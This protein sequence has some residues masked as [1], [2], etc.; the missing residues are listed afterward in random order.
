MINMRIK[1]TEK[2]VRGGKLKHD[3]MIKITTLI[4][5]L[6]GAAIVGTIFN[7]KFNLLYISRTTFLGGLVVAA[8]LIL[9]YQNKKLNDLEIMLG[10]KK[11]YEEGKLNPVAKKV[12]ETIQILRKRMKFMSEEQLFELFALI[13]VIGSMLLSFILSP[14][15]QTQFIGWVTLSMI[16]SALLLG[17]LLIWLI[18]KI[19][20]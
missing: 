14:N 15:P 20:Q 9:A 2:I 8:T 10:W 17:Y 16:L 3:R 19:K 11:E 7:E 13:I 18:R 6:F 4:I 5:T 12:D 1:L